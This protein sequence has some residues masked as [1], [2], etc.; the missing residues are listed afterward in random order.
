[1]SARKKPSTRHG[2][3][4]D[5]VRMPQHLAKDNAVTPVNTWIVTMSVIRSTRFTCV[6]ISAKAL[7][8]PAKEFAQVCEKIYT[9]C[10]IAVRFREHSKTILEHLW[11]SLGCGVTRVIG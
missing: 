9:L 1:M 3:A 5:V 8:F 2:Y 4:T 11:R 7:D 10:V 6:R